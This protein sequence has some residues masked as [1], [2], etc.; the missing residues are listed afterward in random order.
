MGEIVPMLS[1]WFITSIVLLLNFCCISSYLAVE[2]KQIA[3]PPLKDRFQN[4]TKYL[5]SG[6]IKQD[7]RKSD[8]QLTPPRKIL[9]K[10]SIQEPRRL[11]RSKLGRI[12]SLTLEYFQNLHEI[13][14]ENVLVFR[15]WMQF[16]RLRPELGLKEFKV[17]T[18]QLRNSLLQGLENSIKTRNR[19]ISVNDFI[20]S[21]S[22]EIEAHS[23]QFI[24]TPLYSKLA[25]S[26]SRINFLQQ[27]L[28][29][30]VDHVATVQIFQF[31]NL[32]TELDALVTQTEKINA[33][34][35][36]SSFKSIL[37]KNQEQL[38]NEIKELTQKQLASFK[39]IKQNYI[40]AETQILIDEDNF[41]PKNLP[42]KRQADRSEQ[43]AFRKLQ[44]A[45]HL[46]IEKSIENEAIQLSLLKH[47]IKLQKK[48]LN[49]NPSKTGYPDIPLANILF[50]GNPDKSQLSPVM[51]DTNASIEPSKKLTNPDWI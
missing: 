2:P 17:R 41:Q 29:F 9:S 27:S 24:E 25:T 43:I 48:W 16:L 13:F 49:N 50:I 3:I 31:E 15:F 23:I 14:S 40:Y 18:Q 45:F 22:S 8:Y 26:N 7:R 44:N 42:S 51:A 34:N 4:Y 37:L 46:K 30:Y 19:L 36:N 11:K 38:V 5:R 20:K 28:S 33:E 21:L 12:K 39:Q 35:W 32:V 10:D 6:T 1:K 47:Q